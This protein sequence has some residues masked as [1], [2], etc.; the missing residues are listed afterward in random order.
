MATRPHHDDAAYANLGFLVLCGAPTSDDTQIVGR[1]GHSDPH[2][3]GERASNRRTASVRP[4]NYPSEANVRDPSTYS[5]LLYI[6]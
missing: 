4:P 2:H 6:P 5:Y 1:D 3:G